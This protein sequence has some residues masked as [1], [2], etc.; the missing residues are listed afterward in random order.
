[1]LGLLVRVGMFNSRS[2]VRAISTSSIFRGMSDR[3]HDEMLLDYYRDKM[4]VTAFHSNGI[5]TSVA[6]VKEV[7]QTVQPHLSLEQKTSEVELNTK[8]DQVG[9]SVPI[10]C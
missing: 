7:S 8:A 9:V 3:A 6:P 10:G 2:G 1:M 4:I 5:G